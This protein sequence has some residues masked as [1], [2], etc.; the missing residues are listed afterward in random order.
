MP[1]DENGMHDNRCFFCGEPIPKYEMGGW[2]YA[3]G[4]VPPSPARKNTADLTKEEEMH[5]KFKQGPTGMTAT[6]R[7]ERCCRECYIKEHK[8]VSGELPS[9]MPRRLDL[10]E[11]T[12]YEEPPKAAGTAIIMDGGDEKKSEV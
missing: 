9:Q 12:L 2:I 5:V 10:N 4:F 1:Y 3:F 8:R 6:A 11:Y 7:E